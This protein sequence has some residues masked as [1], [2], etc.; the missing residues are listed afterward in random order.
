MQGLSLV[1]VLGQESRKRH[2]PRKAG[3]VP[4]EELSDSQARGLR[5]DNKQTIGDGS[6]KERVNKYIN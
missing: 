6:Q 2:L 4:E 3:L 1:P 5:E